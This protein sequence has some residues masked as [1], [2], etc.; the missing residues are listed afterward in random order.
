MEIIPKIKK[1][2]NYFIHFENYNDELYHIFFND[3]ET[4]EIKRNYFTKEDNVK[5]IKIII[6]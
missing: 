5:K 4:T 2:K 1:L 6:D 3:N